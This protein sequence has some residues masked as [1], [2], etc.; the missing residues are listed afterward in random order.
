VAV[1]VAVFAIV[2]F[3]LPR[4]LGAPIGAFTTRGAYSFVSA[5]GLHPPKIHA[6]IPAPTEGPGGSS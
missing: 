2:D 6:Q 3:A 4:T 1:I 5:P